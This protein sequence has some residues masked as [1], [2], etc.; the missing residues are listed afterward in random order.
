MQPLVT[1]TPPE[2][3]TRALPFELGK[4]AERILT[5]S[6]ANV[7]VEARTVAMAFASETPVER[8]WGLEIL[9]CSP[10]AMRTT[11]LAAGANV[12]CDHNERDVVGVVESTTLG[13]DKVARA[14]ARFGKSVRASEVFV[15]VADGIRQ[16]VSVGYL[17]HAAVLESERDGV[18][19]YRITDWEPYEISIVSVPADIKVGIGRSAPELAATAANTETPS[20]ITPST[21]K[22]TRTMEP[23]VTPAAPVIQTP[24]TRNHAQ[25]ISAIAKGTPALRDAA[26]ASIQAG[27]TVEQFQVEAIRVM[28]AAPTPTSDIG[29]DHKEIRRYSLVRALH[30][31]ANPNNAEAQRAAA[32]ERECSG[33]VEKIMGKA[34]RGIFMPTDVQKRDLVAGT[35]SAGGNLVATDLLSGSFIDILRNAMVINKLGITILP[36]LVGKV[37]IPKQTGAGTAYWVAETVDPTESQQS[38]GQVTMNMKTIGAYTQF[39]RDLLLQSSIAVEQ[40]VQNDLASVVGLGLQQAVINGPGTGG[41]PSGILTQ[42][43]ASILG[44]TNG[45]APTWANIVGLETNVS[46]ANADVG[47]MGYLTNA[48]VRGKLKTT[49]KFSTTNGLPIWGDGNDSPLNGYNTA[50]TNA[51]P[52]NG[53]KGTG[54]NLSSI[55]FGNFADVVIGLWGSLDLT[56]DPYALSKSGGVSVV[57]LQSADVALR[58][59]ESFATMTDAIT[60]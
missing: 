45:A 26:L 37:A 34:A 18:G 58:N 57:A 3:A 12:L 33:A 46:V 22:E 56:V 52:S 49:E 9:D 48:K 36:G 16:N 27:H 31:M 19:T 53:I 38:I 43:A 55:I 20:A 54:T 23:V 21:S 39:T 32:F 47:S 11:R 6:R 15:D 14:V 51:M 28:Y 59:V 40:F 4:P 1:T 7:D 41:A 25:E 42:I 35:A 30:A 8:Y 10:R 2:Q 44:G 5:L 29:M 13:A 50:V 24:A 17:I 60:V